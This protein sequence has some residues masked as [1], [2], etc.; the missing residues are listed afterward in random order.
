MGLK[1][2]LPLIVRE[3]RP[4]G[5]WQ[6]AYAQG[7]N[8]L[9]LVPDTGT[10]MES[11]RLDCFF[12][13]FFKDCSLFYLDRMKFLQDVLLLSLWFQ[14]RICWEQKQIVDKVFLTCQDLKYTRSLGIQ[15]F[16]VIRVWAKPGSLAGLMYS[17]C[18]LPDLFCKQPFQK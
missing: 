14:N 13:T 3:W 1:N 4:R 15:R 12:K 5:K 16:C 17:F 9:F 11:P 8:Y 10:C 7:L 18:L 6:T 2:S